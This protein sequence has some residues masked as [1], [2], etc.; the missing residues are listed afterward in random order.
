MKLKN[1]HFEEKFKKEK[2]FPQLARV[3]QLFTFDVYF[4]TKT[5][6]NFSPFNNFQLSQDCE[7]PCGRQ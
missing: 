5:I 6:T 4:F 7:I 1:F 2:E 3:W